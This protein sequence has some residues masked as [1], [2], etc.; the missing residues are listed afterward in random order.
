MSRGVASRQRLRS[1]SRHQLIDSP[2]DIVAV[3]SAVV[4]F[5]L[6]VR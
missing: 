3:R 5:T 1:A 2:H 4:R 6:L